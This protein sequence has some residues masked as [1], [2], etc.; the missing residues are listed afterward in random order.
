MRL[1]SGWR[2]A[3]VA[4]LVAVGCSEPPVPETVLRPVRTTTV[5]ASDGDRLR[6]FAGVARAGLES[7]LSF[8]VAGTIA[9]L[10]A[11]VGG[12]VE[13]GE[14]LAALDPADYEL[15][16]QEALAAL[17]QAEAAAR[18]AEAD[19][20][21]VRALYEN[22]NVS[23]REL[24]AARA[25]SESSA[26]AVEAAAKRLEQARRQLAYTR[27]SSPVAGTVAARNVELNEN[28]QAGQTVVLLTAGAQPEVAVSLPEQLIADV[29]IGQPVEVTFPALP[30]A[31]FDAVVTE[32]ASAAVGA[33]TTFSVVV[34][35][36]DADPDIRSGM[37]AEVAF[38][39]TAGRPRDRDGGRVMV[40]IVA[41][42][43]DREGRYVFV[44]EEA[45]DGEGVV[46]RRGVAVGELTADGI[47]ILDGLEPGER[48]VTAGV[49]RLSDGERVLLPEPAS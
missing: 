34:Q 25:G 2:L 20:D 9:R 4:G 5:E 31:R 17:A 48:I 13:R 24:D 19:Y 30:E 45:G 18:N 35:L 46:R 12:E 28:V 26:A 36:L 21:R 32:V 38:R 37:A 23:R 14:L 47:E 22:N 41:V 29:A 11:V 42:G 16:V 40:P 44:L 33:A 10:P 39:F 1:S 3:V 43:E 27:L 6:L 15:R 8:R 7:E 49:R